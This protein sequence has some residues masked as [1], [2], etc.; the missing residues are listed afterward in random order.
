MSATL[1]HSIFKL[2]FA[3]ACSVDH[4]L[5]GEAFELLQDE[6][7]ESLEQPPTEDPSFSAVLQTPEEGKPRT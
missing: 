7:P 1:L 6:E 3:Y 4:E 2:M 5:V